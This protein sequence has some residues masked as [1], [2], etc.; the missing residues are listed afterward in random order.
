MRRPT[1]LLTMMYGIGSG[2]GFGAGGWLGMFG[3]IALVVGV[4]L[5]VAWVVGR[6]AP[7]AQPRP[8]VRQPAGQEPLELLRMRLA[9]GEI[10]EAEFRAVKQVLEETR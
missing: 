1:E 10:T 4:V 9:R 5:L 6:V 3:L 2:I 7:A 8:P